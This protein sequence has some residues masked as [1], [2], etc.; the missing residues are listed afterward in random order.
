MTR[1]NG[2]KDVGTREEEKPEAPRELDTQE[3]FTV[4]C[5]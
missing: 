2:T 4:A 1:S 5:E 3:P